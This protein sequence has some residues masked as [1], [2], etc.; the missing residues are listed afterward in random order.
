MS[1]DAD[2]FIFVAQ[3]AV[4]LLVG[5]VAL[6]VNTRSAFME[7]KRGSFELIYGLLSLTLFGLICWQGAR[8]FDAR[9]RAEA[10]RQ[11]WQKKFDQQ[12]RD[13][14]AAFDRANQ[15]SHIERNRLES[16]IS[17]L[18]GGVK[19]VADTIRAQTLNSQKLNTLVKE[20]NK[21]NGI[22]APETKAVAQVTE[23]TAATAKTD[24]TAQPASVDWRGLVLH[25][26][27]IL[28]SHSFTVEPIAAGSGGGVW[29][30]NVY[31]FYI[32]GAAN[33]D[34]VVD[35]DFGDGSP[36]VTSRVLARVLHA[37]SAKHPYN[38]ENV[39]IVFVGVVSTTKPNRS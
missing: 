2:T 4:M 31:S 23:S 9:N 3:G 10:E 16:A 39:K 13:S 25:V 7:R 32:P 19:F 14:N 33:P 34:M 20:T 27:D 29:I 12:R 8:S 1:F 38:P 35:W 5:V 21:G 24:A 6:V 17:N 28:P 15:D 22:L 36:P 11:A 18:S 30:P 26:G 37:F